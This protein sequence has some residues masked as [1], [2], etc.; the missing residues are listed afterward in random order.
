VNASR[1]IPLSQNK[2]QDE[3]AKFY[4]AY[5]NSI[6][7]ESDKE[8]NDDKFSCDGVDD[9]ISDDDDLYLHENPDEEVDDYNIYS[10]YN[11]TGGGDGNCFQNEVL[12]IPPPVEP[13]L[14]DI[15]SPFSDTNNILLPSGEWGKNDQ[16]PHTQQP[17][18]SVLNPSSPS[19]KENGTGEKGGEDAIGDGSNR[20]KWKK[21][22][23]EDD[24]YP[25][26][27]E[28]NL[29]DNT[30]GF[31]KEIIQEKKEGST[32]QG[33]GN[34]SPS[35]STSLLSNP[36][37]HSPLSSYILPNQNPSSARGAAQGLNSHHNIPCS[38]VFP[39]PHSKKLLNGNRETLKLI[40]DDFK[41][42]LFKVPPMKFFADGFSPQL[43][44]KKPSE[45]KFLFFYFFFFI[46]FFF[47]LNHPYY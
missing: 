47:L 46:S 40:P 15:W 2:L 1:G 25:E 20:K 22:R 12:V 41:L 4:N 9:I 17:S 38:T 6:M 21:K 37:L 39:A 11:L 19:V 26:Y 5:Y 14:F 24:Y 16:Q 30:Y 35:S 29:E 3:M 13:D 31:T 43:E 7:G 10:Q 32:H 23:Y 28:V 18:G 33:S 44:D 34:R 45:E 42:L 36:A 8:I 27:D